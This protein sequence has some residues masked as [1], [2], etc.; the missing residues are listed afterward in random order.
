MMLGQGVNSLV[1]TPRASMTVLCVRNEA[2]IIE[3]EGVCVAVR[4]T[5]YG[6]CPESLPRLFEPFYTTKPDGM[7]MGLS[8]CRSIIEA[9]GGRPGASRGGPFFGLRSP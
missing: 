9:H 2:G 8:L 5:G 7:G 3:P 1:A 4:D 6:L